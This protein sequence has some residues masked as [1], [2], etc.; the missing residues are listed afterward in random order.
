MEQYLG[1]KAQHRDRILLYRMGDFYETFFED[2]KTAARVLGIALTTRGKS[3]GEPV[4]LAG[5]PHHSV[6]TYIHR[7]IA[8]GFSVAICEQVEDPATAKGV[9]KRAV[10]EVM[11]PGTI[12]LEEF[13]PAQS[14]AYCLSLFPGEVRTGFAMGDISTG[15]IL[16]GE[17]HPAQVLGLPARFNVRERRARRIIQ[18]IVVFRQ[19]R[20][21][22]ICTV[23]WSAGID[24]R[25]RYSE[26]DA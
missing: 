4:P 3:Q 17:E 24:G 10:T 1:I 20:P 25:G 6:N 14:G 11:T 18:G 26:G 13:L 9:V 19:S 5:V 16:S 21:G 2:A 12:S 8:A 15:E 22:D 7:L 23:L